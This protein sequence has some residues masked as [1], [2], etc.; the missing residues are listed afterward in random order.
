MRRRWKRQS[1]RR[2]P[3]FLPGRAFFEQDTDLTGS[4]GTVEEAI[5]DAE[6]AQQT[7]VAPAPVTQRPDD[8]DDNDR[9]VKDDD[10]Q[11]HE[12]TGG[13]GGGGYQGPGLVG[14]EDADASE[15]SF[16]NTEEPEVAPNTEADDFNEDDA[17]NAAGGS[18]GFTDDEIRLGNAQVEQDRTGFDEDEQGPDVGRSFTDDE[19]RLGNAQVDQDRTGFDE[20]EFTPDVGRPFTE[21][22]KEDA[23][24]IRPDAVNVFTDD[25]DSPTAVVVTED[26]AATSTLADSRTVTDEDRDAA[27]GQDFDLDY[28]DDNPPAGAYLVRLNNGKHIYTTTRPESGEEWSSGTHQEA[29]CLAMSRALQRS[30]TRFQIGARCRTHSGATIS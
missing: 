22:D 17:A 10:A 7:P 5:E 11:A 15:F 25:A 19:I 26:D 24:V 9:L 1:R 29:G 8:D 30:E 21:D 16:E 3:R 13:F 12:D 2:S 14:N 28:S 23:A 4:L 6:N 18:R 27:A 20:D